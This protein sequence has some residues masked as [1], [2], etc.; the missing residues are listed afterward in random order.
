MS[1]QP[2]RRLHVLIATG[3]A[4]QRRRD[5]VHHVD[6][7]TLAS[8]RV[9]V[10][11]IDFVR[12]SNRVH[13]VSIAAQDHTLGSTDGSPAATQIDHTVGSIE[14]VRDTSTG[15]EHALVWALRRRVSKQ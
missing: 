15:L 2:K 4:A 12:A 3:E 13:T 14:W 1:V 6:G 11:T 8:S 9:L 10:R 5:G 7:C